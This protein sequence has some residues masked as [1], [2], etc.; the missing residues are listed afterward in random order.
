MNHAHPDVVR[1]AGPIDPE[2]GLLLISDPD[3]KHH[4]ES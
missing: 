4:A 3:S 2:I 1:A